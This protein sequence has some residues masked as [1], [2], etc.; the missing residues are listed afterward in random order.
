[1]FGLRQKTQQILSKVKDEVVSAQCF[2]VE[3][4]ETDGSEA[5]T[6]RW[7]LCFFPQLEAWIPW[8]ASESPDCLVEEHIL[9]V[10]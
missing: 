7:V 8:R 9:K 6:D 5:K 2:Q 10:L 3:C 4:F 1:M